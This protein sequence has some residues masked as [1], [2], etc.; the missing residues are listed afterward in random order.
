MLPHSWQGRSASVASSQIRGVRSAPVRVVVAD[1]TRMGT[2]LILAA[3]RQEQCFQAIGEV[4]SPEEFALAV[5]RAKPDVAI[6]AAAPRPS[7]RDGFR[8]LRYALT[9]F[10]RLKAVMLLDLPTRDLVVESFRAGARGIICR[11]EEPAAMCRCIYAVHMGE[12]WAT[13]AQLGYVLEVFSRRR[14]LPQTVLDR[15][16]R[17]LLSKRELDVVRCVSEGMTNRDIASHLRLSKHTVKNYMFRIFN[18]LGVS[19]RAELI[20]YA[21]NHS[22]RPDACPFHGTVDPDQC[23]QCTIASRIEAPP[24]DEVAQTHC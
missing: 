10:P 22:C 9:R 23:E 3:L 6:I 19:N 18:K 7:A 14:W 21:I 24:P 8:L 12:I 5:S 13:S 15:E 1:S 17:A 11:D 20:L 16:G 2:Q 4:A